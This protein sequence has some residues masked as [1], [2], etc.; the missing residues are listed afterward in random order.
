MAGPFTDIAEAGT[1]V[2]TTNVSPAGAFPLL[3]VMD[4]PFSVVTIELPDITTNDASGIGATKLAVKS[5]RV[6]SMTKSARV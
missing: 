4:G 2:T 6:L 5:P 3:I 1:F